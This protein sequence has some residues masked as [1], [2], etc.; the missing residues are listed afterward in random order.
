[1]DHGHITV[2]WQDLTC[3]QE[4]PTVRCGT[5]EPLTCCHGGRLGK[6]VLRFL[7]GLLLLATASGIN[8]GARMSGLGVV[9]HGIDVAN[10]L[11]VADASSGG[12]KQLIA[13]TQATIL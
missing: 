12:Q 11:A 2:Y 8:P 6:I 5:D 1:M 7:L 9:P 10:A 3:G 4:L 13:G